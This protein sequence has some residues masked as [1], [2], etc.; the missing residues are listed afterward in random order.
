MSYMSRF[1]HSK[2]LNYYD[3]VGSTFLL[4]SEMKKKEMN[5]SSTGERILDFLSKG[6]NIG[7][8]CAVESE[9]PRQESSR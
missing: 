1:T 5:R 9:I 7:F 2:I 4:F 3:F 6:R 8:F